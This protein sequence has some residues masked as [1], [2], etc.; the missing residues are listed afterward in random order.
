MPNRTTTCSSLLI[1][2]ALA[3]VSAGM[4]RADA[5][6]PNLARKAKVSASSQYSA[7]YRPEMAIDGA[8][9]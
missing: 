6:P 9:G 7:S 5:M 4:V 2:A 8:I 3:V 1:V